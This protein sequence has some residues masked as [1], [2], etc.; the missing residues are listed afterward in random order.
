MLIIFTK[1]SQILFGKLLS[2]QF[3]DKIKFEY[4]FI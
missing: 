1:I 4:K 2:N 3:N